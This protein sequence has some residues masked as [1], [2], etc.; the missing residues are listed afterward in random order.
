MRT[1][2]WI[3]AL[4]GVV[5]SGWS[6]RADAQQVPFRV[7]SDFFVVDFST[8][9]V[10]RF[11]DLNGDGDVQDAGEQTVFYDDS[12]PGPDLAT[13]T[14]MTV[15]PIDGSVWIS[16]TN[17]DIVLRLRDL[18]GDGDANDAG[19]FSIFY[20]LT[21]GIAIASANDLA[22]D[23]NGVVYL[24]VAGT[25]QNPIDQIVRLEDLNNDGDALDMGEATVYLDNTALS[26]PGLAL[27][28]DVICHQG[29]VWVVD[30]TVSPDSILRLR[31]SNNDGDALDL[32]EVTR[33]ASPKAGGAT[34]AYDLAFDPTT[35]GVLYANDTNGNI[36]RFVDLD[37]DGDA[38]D[39]GEH[40][41]FFD[42]TNNA[43]NISL[44]ISFTFT[45][46]AAGDLFACNRSND[47]VYRLT[48]LNSDGDANDV[49]EATIY[50]DSAGTP[51]L[52][53]PLVGA[54]DCIFAPGGAIQQ[55]VNPPRIGQTADFLLDDQ[56][57]GGLSYVAA[58]SFGAAGIP[59]GA[60]IRRIP[61]SPDPLL[62]LSLT[63][64][65]LQQ[66]F[67]GVFPVGGQS[68]ARLAIPAQTALVNQMVH[69]AFV[70]I[71]SSAPSSIRTVSKPFN[72]TI[73]P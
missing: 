24:A 40:T 14:G 12:S 57:G 71:D 19:E 45:V 23:Q 55:G 58:I 66:N 6:A 36:N 73:Q 10:Y 32:N 60:D 17:L 3:V 5:A 37:N 46:D 15:S 54:R 34:V 70:T 43:S 64:L 68:V 8:D 63:G 31:D 39:P 42:S 56:I 69:M 29:D 4:L 67:A 1:R 59:L 27:P 72:F 38:L 2:I 11:N 28:F 30:A 26:G 18:N 44:R 20:D 25:S 35:S 62:F 53:H 33:W 51:P 16:D 21:G 47:V 7:T 22:I 48:D 49:G 52:A 9:E 61:L 65:P 50:A 13:P 41:L